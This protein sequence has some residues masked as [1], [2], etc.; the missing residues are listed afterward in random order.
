MNKDIKKKTFNKIL[1]LK[2]YAQKNNIIFF[3]NLIP[4]LRNVENYP[5]QEEDNLMKNFF[6]INNISFVQHLENFKGLESQN[7]WVS[8]SDPHPNEFS[9]NILSINLGDYIEKK[10]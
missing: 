6:L 7:L 2:N 4:D 1:E 10:E 9:H 3:V 8:N 5:F